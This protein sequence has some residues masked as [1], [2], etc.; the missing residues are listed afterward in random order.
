MAAS[1]QFFGAAAQL[2]LGI[3]DLP[4]TP[5]TSDLETALGA[6]PDNQAIDA[7]VRSSF[8]SLSTT[9]LTRSRTIDPFAIQWNQPG[10]VRLLPTSGTLLG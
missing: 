1:G 5:I 3:A 6:V 4:E 2:A 7:R 9:K 10:D 8:L